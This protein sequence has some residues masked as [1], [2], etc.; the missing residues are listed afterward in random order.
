[1]S[2]GGLRVALSRLT[3]RQEASAARGLAP[4]S[5]LETV[6]FGALFD[7]DFGYPFAIVPLAS[8]KCL[9]ALS[10]VTLIRGDRESMAVN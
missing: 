3:K 1:M 5:F 4:M 2:P 8:S 10:G 6:H 7:T 9:W